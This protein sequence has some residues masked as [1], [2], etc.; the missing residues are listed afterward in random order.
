MQSGR[1][2]YRRRRVTSALSALALATV[3]SSCQ[4]VGIAGSAVI[5]PSTGP[6]TV[7]P[8]VTGTTIRPVTAPPTAGYVVAA[9]PPAITVHRTEQDWWG[10]PV[11]VN[12]Q[13]SLTSDSP[14]DDSANVY[15]QPT[16]A[17]QPKNAVNFDNSSTGK[18]WPGPGLS[19]HTNG[20]IIAIQDGEVYACSGTVVRSAAHNVVVTAGHCVWNI[21]LGKPHSRGGDAMTQLSEI[22][23]VPGAANISEPLR[24]SADGVPEL[25]AP[26]GIWRVDTAYSNHRWLESTWITRS[27]SGIDRTERMHGDGSHDDVAFVT[28][29]PLDGQDIEDVTGAQGLLFTPTAPTSPD[30]NYPTVVVGYP[31]GTPFDGSTQRY[32]A[33][34]Y[35]RTYE[36]DSYSRTASMP[37]AMTPGASGGA[38]FSGF[39]QVEGVGYVYG[40]TSRGGDGE[41]TVALLSLTLD[42]PLYRRVSAA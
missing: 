32:C 9:A 29:R 30:L 16:T 22:W 31:A 19:G 2:G 20:Q 10:V 14:V 7:T 25:D 38:W 21:P 36:G 40:V 17:V 34:T 4:G 37:C 27:G 33:S 28:L 42:Y 11:D 13:S 5:A 39:D 24:L 3:L 12:H 23:F 15:V 1:T 41:L 8:V 18:V 26:D 6:V 35:L